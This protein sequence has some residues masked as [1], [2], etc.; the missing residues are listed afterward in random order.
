MAVATSSSLA[1]FR[2]VAFQA[3]SLDAKSFASSRASLPNA[4]RFMTRQSASAVRSRSSVVR[5]AQKAIH[6]PPVVAD[7]KAAFLKAY[8]KPI[9]SIYNTVIQEILVQQHLTRYNRTYKYD[10]VL[11]LGFVTVFDQLMDGYPSPAERDAIFKAYIEALE[12]SPKTYRE[13]ATRLEQ[14]AA[15]LTADELIDLGSR[16]G[17]VE[18]SLQ[19]IAE[20]AK[21]GTFHYS[22]FFAV[23]LFRL[24]EIAKASEPATLQKLCEALGISQMSVNRDL[25]VYRGLLSKLTQAKELLQDFLQREKA[26]KDERE[27]EKAQTS[28]E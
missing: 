18:R 4:Q 11:A 13:D 9:P 1:L 25:D 19:E 24:L 5:C 7:T 15:G 6:D 27:R 26:K 10:P 20:R 2:V 12:E 16:E 8:P 22:R 14:W 23:G 17:D 28:K 3:S 21:A